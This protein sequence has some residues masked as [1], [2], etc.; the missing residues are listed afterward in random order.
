MIGQLKGKVS[1]IYKNS[2]IIDVSGIGYLVAAPTRTLGK[3]SKS[4]TPVSLFIHTYVREDVIALYGFETLKELSLFEKLISVSG[5]GVK[6]ALAVLSASTAEEITSAVI[7]ADLEFF[8]SVPGIGQKSAQRLIIDVKAAIGDQTDI[9]LLE[10]SSP[11][12]RET[13]EALKQFG[14]KVSESRKALRSIK[15][16]NKM[17]TEQ[18]LKEVLKILGK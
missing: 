15:N 14:F 18:L 4:G 3:F 2:L 7:N 16:K 11:A 13:V 8:T 10:T 5:I 1:Q 9:N 6:I 17:T 12:Y